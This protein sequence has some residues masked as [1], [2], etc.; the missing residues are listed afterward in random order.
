MTNRS[1][2]FMKSQSLRTGQAT[3]PVEERSGIIGFGTEF[4][5]SWEVKTHENGANKRYR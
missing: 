2:I 5:F 1:R 4:L 3:K